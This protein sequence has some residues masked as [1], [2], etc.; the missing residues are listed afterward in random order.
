M[1]YSMLD[2]RL[3]AQEALDRVWF[4]QSVEETEHTDPTL[5]L[6]LHIRPDLF[7]AYQTFHGLDVSGGGCH[8]VGRHESHGVLLRRRFQPLL[9]RRQ[10]DNF[11]PSGV[12]QFLLDQKSDRGDLDDWCLFNRHAGESGLL[13]P[14]QISLFSLFYGKHFIFRSFD[15]QILWFS[16]S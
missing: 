14:E 5:S 10:F 6:R 8:R 4:V 11:R 12:K 7:T 9:R 2:L 16:A 3:E 15:D 13:E 1:R